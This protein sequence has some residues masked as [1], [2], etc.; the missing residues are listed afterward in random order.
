MFQ[1]SELIK[2]CR[3]YGVAVDCWL[4]EA[5]NID[6]SSVVLPTLLSITARQDVTPTT[7]HKNK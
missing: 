2:H 6:F 3:H 1:V 5:A 4:A 7:Q